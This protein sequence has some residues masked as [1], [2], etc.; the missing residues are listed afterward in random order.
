MRLLLSVD[1]DWEFVVFDI[2]GGRGD[3]ALTLASAFPRISV[4]V[5]ESHESSVK[6]LRVRLQR[7]KPAPNVHPI[8]A[9]FRE[10]HS[11]L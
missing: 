3:L 4:H 8:H 11:N 7:S 2:G 10:L 9:D 5:I 6:A 1:G